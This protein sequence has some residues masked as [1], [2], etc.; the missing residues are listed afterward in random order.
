MLPSWLLMSPLYDNM[1]V[2]SRDMSP[3]KLRIVVISH[4]VSYQLKRNRKKYSERLL[5]HSAPAERN[6]V[7]ICTY[8]LS[9]FLPEYS[10]QSLIFSSFQ[11]P[12]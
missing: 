5:S 10:C 11:E 4:P 7:N 12:S 6:S 8:I 2:R 9:R 1:T 3:C